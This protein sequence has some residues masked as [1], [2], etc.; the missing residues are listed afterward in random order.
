[1]NLQQQIKN[2]APILVM[3]Y[4]FTTAVLSLVIFLGIENNIELDHFTQDPASIMNTPFY[5]G[6]FS[7]IGILFWCG[8]A[9]LCFFTNQILTKNKSNQNVRSFLLYSGL[10]S[11]LLMFD[12]L[13]LLH[14]DVLPVYFHLPETIVYVIYINIIIFYLGFFRGE[15]L[16]S[17]Y[18]VLVIASGLIAISQ[19]VDSLPMPIPED[20]FLED[21]VKLF[22][23]MTW[24]T[25]YARYCYQKA[26]AA[27]AEK[28]Q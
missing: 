7:Y 9:M 10:I 15:L 8:A 21:A 14:E 11:T 16:R 18:I 3:V 1:M 4:A 28:K 5:L 17:E 24:F 12:D 27:F 25:Y 19:F 23:I 13:F 6:F 26:R 22:G 2:T 20:S